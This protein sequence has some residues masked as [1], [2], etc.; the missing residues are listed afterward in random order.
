MPREHIHFVTGKLA[1]TALRDV[2]GELAP[3]AGFDYSV[4]VLPISVAALMPTAWIAS[5]L[6]VPRKTTRVLLP[7]HCR[8]ELNVVQT[9]AGCAVDRGPKDLRELPEFFGQSAAPPA[10]YGRHEIEILAEINHAP[11]L[12]QGKLL[13]LAEHYHQSGADVIDLGC[14]PGET[15]SGVA[16]A[17]SALC[18]AGYRV[19]IDSLN[20]SE[21]APAVAAGAELVLSVNASNRDAAGDWGSEVVVIPDTT[22]HAESVEATIEHLDKIGVRWRLDP[23]V[24][25]IG[26]GFARSLGRFLDMRRRYPDA[27]MFMGIGNLTELTD[28]DS[29]GINVLLLGFCQEVGISS[30]LTTEV[31]NWARSS[32]RECD[33]ARRLVY[34]AVKHQVLP[35]HLEPGLNLL[36]DAKL[37][38]Y[39]P[40]A[41]ERMSREIKDPNYRLFAEEDELHV[42]GAGI[43]LSDRD[44]FVLQDRL[45]SLRNRPLSATHAFYLGYEMSKAVTAL[46]LGKNYRQ[47]QALQWGLLTREEVNQRTDCR[48][49]DRVATEE[50]GMEE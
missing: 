11:E 19:S 26:F 13:A 22:E 21:I 29:S 35:K 2:L 46:T 39:P 3:K 31:I 18:D 9:A 34:H 23:V 4:E 12:T 44:P 15:W 48:E 20:P 45:L 30:I 14:H 33:M 42:V 8:G 5:R 47:D 37:L 24:E 17:V 36:R 41:L 38:H 40:G 28:V 27:A 7:G 25:P 16:D 6:S 49:T 50:D 10:D 43:H 32:V 1:A